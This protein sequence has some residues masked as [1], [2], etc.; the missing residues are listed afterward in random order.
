M[1]LLGGRQIQVELVEGDLDALVAGR[2]KSEAA[3]DAFGI[4]GW[5]IGT[6]HISAL[7]AVLTGNA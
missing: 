3:L 2:H 6:G 1:R 7:L 4:S 5:E